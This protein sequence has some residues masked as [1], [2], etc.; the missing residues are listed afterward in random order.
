MNGDK[1]ASSYRLWKGEKGKRLTI[2]ARFQERNLALSV[3]REKNPARGPY[4]KR[5]N[6][7]RVRD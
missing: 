1:L 3:E 6:R 5:L 2:A 4:R 7:S